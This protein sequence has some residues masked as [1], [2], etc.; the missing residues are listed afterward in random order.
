MYKGNVVC[1]EL[2]GLIVQIGARML[3]SLFLHGFV[4]FY[5]IVVLYFIV[6]TVTHFNKMISIDGLNCPV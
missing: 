2:C 3:G 5:C 1:K 6:M 4:V